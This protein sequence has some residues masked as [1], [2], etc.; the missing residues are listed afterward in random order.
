MPNIAANS[1]AAYFAYTGQWS[2][3][4]SDPSRRIWQQGDSMKLR[5]QGSVLYLF[6]TIT[7]P[8]NMGA[9]NGNSLIQYNVTINKGQSIDPPCIGNAIA[10]D[11]KETLICQISSLDANQLTNLTL[12]MAAL[13]EGSSGL[14]LSRIEWTDPNFSNQF[15]QSINASSVAAN[16]ISWAL[17]AQDGSSCTIINGTNI[18]F[19][20]EGTSVVVK[21]MATAQNLNAS[22]GV[23]LDNI[24]ISSPGDSDRW[25]AYSSQNQ[26]IDLYRNDRLTS[27]NHTLSFSDIQPGGQ[28]CVLRADVFGPAPSATDAPSTT[29][30]PSPSVSP[31]VTPSLKPLT[32]G[33]LAGVVIG[34]L[35][36]AFILPLR[37]DIAWCA[38]NASPVFKMWIFMSSVKTGI[39]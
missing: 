30:E 16:S 39:H 20:F 7:P 9:P 19:G 38:F 3:S 35:A 36:L 14:N 8:T 2:S 6:G 4:T 15:K 11:P 10:G 32:R 5:I 34:V 33:Q 22:Y 28:F 21:G 25:E 27:A 31:P 26:V 24:V 29:N 23:F 12:S 13:A 17:N 1:T 37:I 18:T